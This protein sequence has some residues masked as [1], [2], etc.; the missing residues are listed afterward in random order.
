MKDKKQKKQ[1]NRSNQ[2]ALTSPL[3]RL[4]LINWKYRSF[5]PGNKGVINLN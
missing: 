1:T 4:D 5:F 3:I 2:F